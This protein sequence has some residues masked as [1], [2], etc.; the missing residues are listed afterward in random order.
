MEKQLSDHEERLLEIEKVIFG[1]KEHNVKG[2]N[3]KL[4]EMYTIL[5]Q[6][7]GIKGLFG[8][9]ILFGATLTV[10]KVWIFGK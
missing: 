6:A 4:D 5:V 7:K 8:T 3:E 1:D 2:M 9:I 10:I